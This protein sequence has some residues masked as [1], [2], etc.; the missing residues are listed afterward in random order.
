MF[1]YMVSPPAAGSCTAYSID[2]IG[3]RAM[4]VTSVCQKSV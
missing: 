3:G 2:A 1:V 4:N